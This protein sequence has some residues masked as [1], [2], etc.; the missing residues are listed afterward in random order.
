MR[1]E[2]LRWHGAW[3]GARPARRRAA[4]A[5]PAT[6]RSPIL[7]RATIRPAAP[8]RASTARSPRPARDLLRAARACWRRSASASG[9]V[10]RQATF[11]LW[12]ALDDARAYAYGARRP[13]RGRAPHARRALVPRGA[14]RALR[15]LRSGAGRATRRRARPAGDPPTPARS[16]ASSSAT[17][18]RRRAS[19]ACRRSASVTSIATPTDYDRC[20]AVPEAGPR[21]A[22]A[23]QRRGGRTRLIRIVAV[24]IESPAWRVHAVGQEPSTGESRPA[25]PRRRRPSPRARRATGRPAGSPGARR[26]RAARR[27]RRPELAASASAPRQDRSGSPPPGCAVPPTRHDAAHAAHPRAG[28]AQRPEPPVRRG[29]VDRAAHARR[30]RARGRPGERTRAGDDAVARRRGASTTPRRPRPPSRRRA[31]PAR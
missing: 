24:P 11:S 22:R 3:G 6:A 9:R 8:A 18:A 20:T 14:L 10:A 30:S 17:R 1:L 23:T 27:S 4:G 21:A 13:P 31:R 28:P 5:A 7:T 16:A 15:A 26:R 2:P 19:R 12:R 29:A 25:T